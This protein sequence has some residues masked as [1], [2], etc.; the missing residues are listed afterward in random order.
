MRVEGAMGYIKRLKYSLLA[1]GAYLNTGIVS[2]NAKTEKSLFF[3]FTSFFTTRTLID[4][5]FLKMVVEKSLKK[6]KLSLKSTESSAP[7]AISFPPQ[8]SKTEIYAKTS[9]NLRFENILTYINSKK[10]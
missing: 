10:Q 2:L 1:F 6:E 3:C 8:L 4:I 7:I 9:T 5:T